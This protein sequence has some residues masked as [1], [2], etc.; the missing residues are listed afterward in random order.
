M[1]LYGLTWINPFGKRRDF[2]QSGQQLGTLA[3]RFPMARISDQ[4]GGQW[5][6]E[7]EG[8]RAS[9]DLNYKVG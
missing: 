1:S 4:G 5:R 3:W 2:L 7:R 9:D 8:N 6:W